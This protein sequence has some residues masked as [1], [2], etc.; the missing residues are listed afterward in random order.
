MHITRAVL[1]Q[2]LGFAKYL[3]GLSHGA[4]LLKQLCDHILFNAAIWIHTPAKV[5]KSQLSQFYVYVCTGLKHFTLKTLLEK[6][7]TL[8]LNRTEVW[9]GVWLSCFG[10]SVI[11]VSS[12]TPSMCR[13]GSG[14]KQTDHCICDGS[15]R[16]E[17]SVKV[18]YTRQ[19]ELYLL[20]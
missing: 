6:V 5:R 3:D 17:L 8:A 14:F 19:T 12:P 20:I 15:S 4:P 18:T 2:F 13:Q 7:N 1:E 9:P 10:L 11:A 16:V